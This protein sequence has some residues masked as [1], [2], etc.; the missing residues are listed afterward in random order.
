MNTVM[1]S[2]QPKKYFAQRFA[3]WLALCSMFMIFA[4][5][6]SA[7]LVRRAQ[8]DWLEFTMPSEFYISTVVIILSSITMVLANHHYKNDNYKT[9]RFFLGTTFVLG[10]AF[11]V[12][13]IMGWNTLDARGIPLGGEDSN[14]AGSFVHLISRIHLLHLF[15]GLFFLAI[16]LIRAM[17]I[18]RNPANSLEKNINP[19][20]G[21]RMDL[22]STYWHFVDVLWVYLFLF[23]I[24][25]K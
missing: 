13:Q 25:N 3:L 17:F 9:F 20:K 1:I 24:I 5:L 14:V 12:L 10:I 15:G 22:L 21:V 19:T 2:P 6:T 18:F 11:T 8:D 4:G 16:A 7:W 23:F